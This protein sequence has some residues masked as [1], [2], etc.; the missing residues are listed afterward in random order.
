M[1]EN[2]EKLKIYE[3][4]CDCEICSNMC[5]APCCGTPEEINSL[6]EKGYGKKLMLDDWPEAATMLKPAL[7][8][9]GCEK[10]PYNT[11]SIDG[12]IFWKKGKCELHKLNLK[13]L[14]G[15]IA[16]HNQ[17]KEVYIDFSMEINDQWQ[18]KSALELI[19]KWKNEYLKE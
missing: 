17:S 18:K 4:E 19:E 14:G 11:S 16:H 2:L 13:P 8:Y 6:I 1:S 9:H 7:K 12:C 3:N 15:R 10:A 5:R